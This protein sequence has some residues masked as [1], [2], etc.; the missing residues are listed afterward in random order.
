[1]ANQRKVEEF[2]TAVH[3]GMKMNGVE[4]AKIPVGAC[5]K[6]AY[7]RG[8]IVKFV[9]DKL[10]VMFDNGCSCEWT[11][12]TK[13]SIANVRRLLS[14]MEGNELRSAKVALGIS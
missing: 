12:E 5:D 13:S 9:N 6:C 2:E 1:M 11:G 8:Y 4:S 3:R 10:V 7:S 14:V